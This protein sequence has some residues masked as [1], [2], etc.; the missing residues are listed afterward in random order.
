M[1]EYDFYY[2]KIFLFHRKLRKMDLAV[3][4]CLDTSKTWIGKQL[5]AGVARFL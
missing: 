2:I 3:L 5:P 1:A 4:H